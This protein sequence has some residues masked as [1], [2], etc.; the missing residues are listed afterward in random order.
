MAAK[1]Y[2]FKVL[3]GA[4]LMFAVPAFADDDDRDDDRRRGRGYERHFDRPYYHPYDRPR[5][6]IVERHVVV[7]HAPPA[8]IYAP[9]P[10]AIVY[11]RAGYD[12]GRMAS[13]FL[14]SAL[15]AYFGHAIAVGR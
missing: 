5:H 9:P 10:P 7:R 12:D 2:W 3:A 6:V 4:A 8:V 11:E 15:G 14:G 13:I 1:K